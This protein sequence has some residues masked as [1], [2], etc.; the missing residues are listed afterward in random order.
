[1]TDYTLIR[2]TEQVIAK[3]QQ[4]KQGLLQDLLTRGVDERGDLRP[5]PDEAQHL[6]RDSPLGRIP[7]QWEHSPLSDHVLIQHGFAFEGRFFTD[8][9][10]GLVLLT[11]GNFHR[12]GGLYF[13]PE[14][15][16]YYV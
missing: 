1:V 8:R 7:N 15:T 4:M 10:D 3:L 12:D 11:P 9:P 6:Y 2:Q 16:K 13:S 14:N 5:T